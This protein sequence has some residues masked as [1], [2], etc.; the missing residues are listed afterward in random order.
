MSLGRPPGTRGRI[1]L[2]VAGDDPAA[3]AIIMRLIN[4]LGFDPVDAGGLDES[5]RQQPGTPV[6]TMDFDADGV[7]YAL[8]NA[9]GKRGPQWRASDNSPGTFAKPA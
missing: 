9:N 1:A 8:G 2:P 4:D 5:W 6:Y 3:K 7:R